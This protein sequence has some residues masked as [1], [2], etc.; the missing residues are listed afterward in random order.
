MGRCTPHARNT[1]A[2][3]KWGMRLSGWKRIVICALSRGRNTASNALP[4][5]DIEI[6]RE[7]SLSAA[8]LKETSIA[9]LDRLIRVTTRVVSCMG[10]TAPKSTY[11]SLAGSDSSSFISH[12]SPR[13][14]TMMGHKPLIKKGIFA[15]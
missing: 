8:S 14:W 5:R 1:T 11:C 7:R 12:P 13:T 10:R 9:L 6:D 15:S 3:E 2:S 4:P